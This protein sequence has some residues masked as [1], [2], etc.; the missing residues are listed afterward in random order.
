MT[1]ICLFK[2]PDNKSEEKLEGLFNDLPCSLKEKIQSTKHQKTRE[3]RILVYSWLKE[4]LNTLGIPYSKF[5]S[6]FAFSEKGKP[7]VANCD[8]KFSLSHT[9]AV[10]AV[11]FSDEGEIGV[12][13]E[14]I[15]LSKADVTKK[16]ASRFFGDTDVE[17]DENLAVLELWT[18]D[19]SGFYKEAILPTAKKIES[20]DSFL[21]WTALEA[22][23]KCN[24]GGFFALGDKEHILKN[25]KLSSA[26][27]QIGKFFYAI[28]LA[29]ST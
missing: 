13:V 10:A 7:Y 15:N 11:A 14:E 29:K 16:V 27:V 23:L 3:T 1:K 18:F 24:G 26:T 9:D 4:S 25:I 17:T 2:I 8:I 19:E 20:S 5:D 6:D 28:S 21:K 12:D 22:A